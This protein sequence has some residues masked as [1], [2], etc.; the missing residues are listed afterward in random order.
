LEDDVV[1]VVDLEEAAK[2]AEHTEAVD[3]KD[4]TLHLQVPVTKPKP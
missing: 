2:P 1:K 4:G 3:L